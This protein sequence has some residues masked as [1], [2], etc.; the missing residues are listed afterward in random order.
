LPMYRVGIDL[1]ALELLTPIVNHC[2]LSILIETLLQ[3]P[4]DSTGVKG[5][6]FNRF[7]LLVPTVL[8]VKTVA[9]RFVGRF[10]LDVT[11]IFIEFCS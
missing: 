4:R 2:V 10:V 9:A 11:T 5:E 7:I 1:E 8:E 6:S 3:H